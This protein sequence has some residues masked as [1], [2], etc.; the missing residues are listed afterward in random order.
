MKKIISLFLSAL[1]SLVF[2][3]GCAVETGGKSSSSAG[4]ES[5][6]SGGNNSETENVLNEQSY[7]VTL[8]LDGKQF[9]PGNVGMYAQWTGITETGEI[10]GFTKAEFNENGIAFANGL[11]GEYRVTL[12]NVPDGYA[13]NPNLYVTSGNSRNIVIQMYPIVQTRATGE[14]FYE[15]VISIRQLGV[16]RVTLDKVYPHKEG[17]YFQFNIP[18]DGGVYSVQSIVDI[19]EN[20]INPVAEIYTG[21]TVYKTWS[22]TCD[23]G[24]EF[25]NGSYTKNFYFEGQASSDQQGHAV[26][27]FAVRA[28]TNTGTLPMTVDFLV[29]RKD[30][31][32]STH[33]DAEMIY[34]KECPTQKAPEGVGTWTGAE[35]HENGQWIFNGNNYVYNE[36]DGFWHVGTKDGPY[37]YVNMTNPDRLFKPFFPS[38]GE[39]YVEGIPVSLAQAEYIVPEAFLR[40]AQLDKETGERT[41]KMIHYKPMIEEQYAKVCNSDGRCLL[42]EELRWF[43][44]EMAESKGYFNDGYGWVEKYSVEVCGYS[45]SALEDDQWLFACGYYQ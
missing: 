14:D 19:M 10:T 45:I 27:P 34:A 13:Y 15:N 23:G 25:E 38:P 36:E 8:E 21:S 7:T 26:I 28:T 44:Q 12:G 31:Y 43:L 17:V 33:K 24:V 42:T 37:V 41:G 18:V 40:V 22:Y 5:S 20:N 16:Y 11:D 3:C 39:G 6:N 4:G 32:E 30:D 1:L 35:T 2:L 29:W 9:K